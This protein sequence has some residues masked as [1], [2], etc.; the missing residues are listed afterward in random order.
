MKK[1]FSKAQV[2]IIISLVLLG[3]FVALWI[4]W[5]SNNKNIFSGVNNK[6]IFWESKDRDGQTC[7]D[8]VEPWRILYENYVRHHPDLFAAYNTS[9]GSQTIESWGRAH[10][11]KFGK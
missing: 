6:N 10:Y 9:G 3:V 5:E 7:K 1:K 4:I 8:N 2:L 11:E